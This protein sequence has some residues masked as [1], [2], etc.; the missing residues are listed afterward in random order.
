MPSQKP[1]LTNNPS[2]DYTQTIPR[3]LWRA[4][5]IS[6]LAVVAGGIITLILLAGGAADPPRAGPLIWQS[7][8]DTAN[9]PY[10]TP[11]GMPAFPYTL[12]V[13]GQADGPW[14]ITFR[15]TR[16]GIAFSIV[17]DGQ[18]FFAVPPFQSDSIPFIHIRPESNKIALNVESSGQATLRINDEIAWRGVV[19]ESNTAQIVLNGNDSPSDRL[20]IQRIALYAPNPTGIPQ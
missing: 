16:G 5:W 19:P 8:R 12:E 15:N 10:Y 1:T 3:G 17:L 6:L 4:A 13:T 20:V 7:L 18:G 14:E 2:S 9:S 11:I